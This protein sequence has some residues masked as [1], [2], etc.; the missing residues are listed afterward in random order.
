MWEG[1]GEPEGVGEAVVGEEEEVGVGVLDG[2]GLAV[3]EG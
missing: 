1:E 3:A 2:V